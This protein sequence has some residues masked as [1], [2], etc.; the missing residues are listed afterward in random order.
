MY[1][2]YELLRAIEFWSKEN[3]IKFSKPVK[4]ILSFKW[5]SSSISSSFRPWEPVNRAEAIKIIL[6]ASWIVI[7]NKDWNFI[8]VKNQ[9]FKKYVNFAKSK[10]VIFWYSNWSFKPWD[11]ITRWEISKMLINT[12]E[13]IK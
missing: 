3:S 6:E 2:I 8:D 12:I 1:I 13:M 11:N 7:E 9:W 5:L 4:L 10:W